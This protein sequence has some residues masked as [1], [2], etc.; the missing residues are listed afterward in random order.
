MAA[1]E[2]EAS[3]R[4]G[5]NTAASTADET[6]PVT[7]PA[8]CHVRECTLPAVA[9]C[10]SCER[11]CC[12]HHVRRITIERRDELVEV[13]GARGALGRVPTRTETYLL[14]P[15]CSTKPISARPRQRSTVSP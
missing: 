5:A 1:E 4:G 10:E 15:R 12:E 2:S 8:R 11:G 14:C 13:R 7:N 6:L 3:T 9:A